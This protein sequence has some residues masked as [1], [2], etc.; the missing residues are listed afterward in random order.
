[1]LRIQEVVRVGQ[2]CEQV[3]RGDGGGMEAGAEH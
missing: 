1:M 2:R 3:S